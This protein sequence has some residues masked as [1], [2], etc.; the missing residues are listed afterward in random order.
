MPRVQGSRTLEPVWG[1][2]AAGLGGALTGTAYQ[3]R[4]HHTGEQSWQIAK[5]IAK[6]RLYGKEMCEQVQVPLDQYHFSLGRGLC[7]PRMSEDR[8]GT[9]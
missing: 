7:V 6:Q 9:C 5:Q 2:A 3:E 1:A 8:Y 4:T